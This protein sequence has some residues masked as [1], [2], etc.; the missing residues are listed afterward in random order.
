MKYDTCDR[1]DENA[2]FA[3]FFIIAHS[4][5]PS[6]CQQEIKTTACDIS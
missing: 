3:L 5:N 2:I 4:V 6:K 1:A